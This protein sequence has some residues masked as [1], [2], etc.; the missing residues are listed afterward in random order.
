MQPDKYQKKVI[1]YPYNM[2]TLAGAGTGKTFCIVKKI[3]FLKKQ[4][5]A[6]DQDFLVISFTNESVNDLK[7]KIK[8]NIDI[9]TFHKL[10]LRIVD[11]KYKLCNESL[12]IYIINE[13]FISIITKTEKRRLLLYFMEIK[14]NKL[15][16]NK[17]FLSFKKMIF[18]Y[19]KLIKANN[20]NLNYLKNIYKTEKDTFLITIIIK[21]YQLYEKE[22]LSQGIIDLD[23]LIINASR[24]KKQFKYKYIFVDEFQDTSQVRFDLIKNIYIYSNSYIYFFGDDFQSIYH[25][26][27]CNINI[28]LNIKS[29]IPNIKVFKLKQTFRNSYELISIANSFILKNKKQLKKDMISDKHISKPIEIIYYSNKGITFNKIIKKLDLKTTL[30]LGRN[31]NDIKLFTN[32]PN[33]NYL[34][35]HKSKGLEAENVVIINMANDIYGFPNKIKNNYLLNKI[36]IYDEIKY[37][38]ERRLFYV[39]LTRTKNKVYILVP[40][41][42]PSIFIKELK[43]MV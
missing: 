31:A 37:A 24:I 28:M 12:L 30:F 38:E 18:T 34:T 8:S 19:I 2:L 21:I 25:F 3:D 20:L 11:K 4:Y 7:K 15:M 41:K 26:S 16:I 42:N 33:I 39:A 22:K 23:D 27:G 10:A 36:N 35:I 29:Y 14:Y 6:K 40:K 5:D 17:N 43:K 32:N 13:F 1:E 9:L